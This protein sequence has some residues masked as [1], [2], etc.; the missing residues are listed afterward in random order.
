MRFTL[1]CP[2]TA[3]GAQTPGFMRGPYGLLI[4]A[5][6]QRGSLEWRDEPGIMWSAAPQRLLLLPLPCAMLRPR[7]LFPSPLHKWW[8]FRCPEH[9]TDQN[10][11]M[12]GKEKSLMTSLE[13]SHGQAGALRGVF[14]EPLTQ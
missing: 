12:E 1:R 3:G 14:G 9:F 4:C 11:M 7:H 5:A 8:H 13:R 10:Y 2:A 6:M